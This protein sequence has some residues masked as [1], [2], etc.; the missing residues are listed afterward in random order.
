MGHND[1][2]GSSVLG[3]DFDRQVACC[4]PSRSAPTRGHLKSDGLYLIRP[5][6]FVAASIPLQNTTDASLLQS[7]MAAQQIRQVVDAAESQ[8]TPR[9]QMDAMVKGFAG[10]VAK[11]RSLAAVMVFD[12]GVHRVL[13]LQPDWGDLI[14]RQLA[15]L[16]Q[17]DSGATGV[18]KATALLTGLAGAATGAPVDI[19]EHVLIE[20]LSEI[21]RR[22][23]GLRQPRRQSDAQRN[24]D[25]IAPKRPDPAPGRWKDF[26]AEA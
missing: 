21:G 17:L 15:L 11:N 20:E 1:D 23:M 13:Q 10:V 14:A 4:L 8:R 19:D 12:P 25:S 16:M 18:I 22:T 9:T 6:E 24:G 26:L 3:F 7:A 2:G 5:D